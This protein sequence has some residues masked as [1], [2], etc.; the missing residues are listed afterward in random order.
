MSA[1]ADRDRPHLPSTRP[2]PPLCKYPRRG[3]PHATL[4]C[5]CFLRLEWMQRLFVKVRVRGHEEQTGTDKQKLAEGRRSRLRNDFMET[6]YCESIA[7]GIS[8]QTQA[9]FDT[10]DLTV[11]GFPRLQSSGQ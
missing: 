11:T 10:L 8:K 3:R 1:G 6:L 5:V 2:P 9:G 4:L 7:E